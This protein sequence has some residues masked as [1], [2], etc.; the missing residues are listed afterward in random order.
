MRTCLERAVQQA[1]GNAECWAMLSVMY[2]NEY[3]HWDNRRARFSRPVAP[4]RADGGRSRAVAIPF[5]TT[6]WLRLSSSGGKFRPSELPRNGRFRSTRWMEP[7]PRS[8]ACSWRTP[9][10]GSAAAPCRRRVMQLNPNHPG[11]YRYTAWH[12]AYRKKDYRKALDVALRL[13]APEELLHARGAGHLLRTTGPDGSG[14]QGAPGDAR[15]EAGLRAGRAR[16]AREMDRPGFGGA[17]DGRAPQGGAG[18]ATAAGATDVGPAGGAHAYSR[19]PARAPRGWTRAFWVAV[20]PFKSHG[21][22]RRSSRRWRRACPK[23]SSPGC[24]ASRISA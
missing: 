9:E 5:R 12:D 1:P 22:Q 16:V 10:T 23:R 24:R 2:A 15:A 19:G 3:G 8:W 18:D 7:R 21:R 6:R 11:W 20:L 14:A 17:T 4:G 13:N